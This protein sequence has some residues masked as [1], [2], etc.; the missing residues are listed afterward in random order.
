MDSVGT[1]E[2]TVNL[3]GVHNLP[4]ANKL[5][6]FSTELHHLWLPWESGHAELST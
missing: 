4:F 6:W 5:R 2:L 3:E 1:S